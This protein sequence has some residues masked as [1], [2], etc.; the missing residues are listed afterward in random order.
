MVHKDFGGEL[1][2][3]CSADQVDSF[4][5]RADIPKLVAIEISAFSHHPEM[6]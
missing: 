1:G 6:S 2:V 5:I 3:K 4:L